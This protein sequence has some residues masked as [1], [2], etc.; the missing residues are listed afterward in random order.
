M[1][2]Y[3][4]III[5]LLVYNVGIAQKHDNIWFWGSGGNTAAIKSASFNFSTTPYTLDSMSRNMSMNRVGNVISD[6][7]GQLLFYSNGIWI[8][9]HSHQMMD[10]GD[11]LNPGPYTNQARPVGYFV[12]E[13]AMII[14]HP[15][16]HNKYYMFHQ[17]WDYDSSQANF[18]G[19]LYYTLVD[20]NANNGLGRVELKNQIL[21]EGLTDSICAGQLEMVK[22]ANGY[23][24]W[25]LQP[26]F[27]KN[28]FHTFLIHGDSI[29][30]VY[31]QHVGRQ[32]RIDGPEGFG[33]AVFTRDGRKYLRYDY[34]NQLDI[35]DFDR[36]TGRLSRHKYVNI[37][38][39]LG[40]GMAVS[41]SGQFIYFSLFTYVLQYDLWA[42]DIEASRDT[43][44]IFDGTYSY[45]P[46]FGHWFYLFELAPDNKIYGYTY[47][48][49]LHVINNPDARGDSC[50]FRQHG[51][52]LPYDNG[53]FVPNNP[54]Y[55]LA[56]LSDTACVRRE[57]G[58]S[59]IDGE[60]VVYSSVA[61]FAENPDFLIYPNPA[62]A[63]LYIEIENSENQKAVILI[64][65]NLGQL[66][67]KSDFS[68]RYASVDIKGLAAGSY[69][70]QLILAG[71]RAV[72]K[73]V[74]E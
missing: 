40:R 63:A 67:A 10:N 52:L 58:S 32:N 38:T 44:A 69:T 70:C 3:I 68:G 21:L 33:Q 30:K 51:I 29:T 55:R 17:G 59:Y 12:W 57:H 15:K 7:A 35:F 74:K 47:G 24:W 13:S 61:T 6:T 2:L 42:A 19:R 14:P 45:D 9:N 34:Q 25:L 64:Y 48:P 5:S 36:C 53:Q 50:D 56:A 22:H 11:S 60:E 16:Q 28:G 46:L 54:N 66:V 27:G 1:K 23:D 71:Q 62:T 4:S 43:V 65:N 49:Y 18:L 26:I 73:F 8:N 39:S 20:M 31:K 72:R 41:P 37:D